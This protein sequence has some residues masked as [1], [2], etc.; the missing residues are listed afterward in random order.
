LSL[1]TVFVLG[2]LVGWVAEWLFDLMFFRASDAEAADMRASRTRL[3]AADKA[4][5][6]MR[7]QRDQAREELARLHA[8]EA[9]AADPTTAAD[10]LTVIGGI[11]PKI[12]RL[13]AAAGITTFDRLAATEVATLRE[14]LAGSGR[15]FG[16]AS[17]ELWPQQ[18]RRAAA[19][20]GRKGGS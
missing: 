16:L 5:A 10:D 14:I 2:V 9:A 15:R 6:E 19:E 4:V 8:V 13:R 20:T 7:L 12:S 18:A 11:G 17:P 3:T 1:L